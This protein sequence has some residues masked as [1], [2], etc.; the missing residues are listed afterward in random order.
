MNG[1]GVLAVWNDC[2]AGRE[3]TYEKWYQTEHLP[4]RL[5]VPGFKRG[6]RYQAIKGSPE[7]F[8]WYEVASPDVLRS[9]D[10]VNCLSNPTPW[11]QEIMAGTF[12]NASRTVCQRLVI[13]GETFGSIAITIR[14]K[15]N[16]A[17][18]KL[19]DVLKG[20]YEPSEIA[21]IEKWTASEGPGDGAKAEEEIRGPD[22]K[23]GVCFVVETIRAD[24]A[25]SIATDLSKVFT[26]PD[27]GVYRLL[28]ER[29]HQS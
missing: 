10:Y 27:I 20:L 9:P 3:N 29:P 8:T 24:R 13:A 14:F 15:E 21:R 18:E 19:Q 12:L 17:E 7:F 28:C 5:G 16:E 2:A 23:I 11:T 25:E 26:L 1:T 22:D 4:E 6:R